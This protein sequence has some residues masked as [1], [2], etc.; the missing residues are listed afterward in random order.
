VGLRGGGGGDKF[1]K[2]SGTTGPGKGASESFAI[3]R[4]REGRGGGGG[5]WGCVGRGGANGGIF[6][7]HNVGVFG[8]WGKKIWGGIQVNEIDASSQIIKLSRGGF[9]SVRVGGR[10]TSR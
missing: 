2:N 8:G 7:C 1:K 9:S 6:F 4:K 3:Q 5:G 10:I